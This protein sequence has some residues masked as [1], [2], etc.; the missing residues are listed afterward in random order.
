[1]TT[2]TEGT[3]CT[4]SPTIDMNIPK[5]ESTPSKSPTTTTSTDEKEWL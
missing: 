2:T 5:E 4:L 1:M 3:A